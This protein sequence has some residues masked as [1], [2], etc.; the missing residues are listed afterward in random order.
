MI[1]KI[2]DRVLYSLLGILFSL[3]L[4]ILYIYQNPPTIKKANT[5]LDKL[6]EY[7]KTGDLVFLS[8]DTY[9]ERIIRWLTSSPFSHVGMLLRSNVDNQLYIW[10]ADIGQGFREG[11]RLMLLTDKFK[12]YKGLK[13]CGW[14]RLTDY[15]VLQRYASKRPPTIDDVESILERYVNYGM[16]TWMISWIL[17]TDEG[18]WSSRETGDV[19]CSELI[20]LT[21]QDLGMIREGTILAKY[22]PG[23]ID[24]GRLSLKAGYNYEETVYCDFSGGVFHH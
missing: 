23:D 22:S 13:I 15:G 6:F 1:N 3:L 20:S 17:S 10:E 16:D 11:P 9:A 14:K 18:S 8:G 5:P 19:F 4:I 24:R 2:V 12:R 7:A 21:M